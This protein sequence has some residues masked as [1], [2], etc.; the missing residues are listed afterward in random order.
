MAAQYTNWIPARSGCCS[1]SISPLVTLWDA[2]C[3]PL[4]GRG[5]DFASVLQD[6]CVCAVLVECGAAFDGLEADDAGVMCEECVNPPAAPSQSAGSRV[7]KSEA[8]TLQPE[9][10]DRLV[11]ETLSDAVSRDTSPTT[12]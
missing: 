3:E 12:S 8:L 5:F 1:E 7:T 11:D 4:F 6:E 2:I 10:P 9:I